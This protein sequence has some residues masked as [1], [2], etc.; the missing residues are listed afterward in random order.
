MQNPV[1]DVAGDV[2]VDR[3]WIHKELGR[4]AH[5]GVKEILRKV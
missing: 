1:L 3:I 2:E 4:K 5:S